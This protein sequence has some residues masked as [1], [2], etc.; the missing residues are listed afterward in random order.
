MASLPTHPAPPEVRIRGATA[1]DLSAAQ[2]FYG[3]CGYGGGAIADDDKV[4]LAEAGGEIV[5]IGRLSHQHGVL[6]L[7]G[8]QVA[9]TLR[10]NGIGKRILQRLATTIGT[11][12]CWCLPYEHLEGF[13]GSAGFLAIDQS[14]MPEFL[15]ERLDGYRARG[16]RVIAMRRPAGAGST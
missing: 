1:A 7:R 13:Y 11:E 10:G 4:L 3:Q 5:G 9:A 16:L 14:A 8:M 2:R 15:R 6:C 12:E